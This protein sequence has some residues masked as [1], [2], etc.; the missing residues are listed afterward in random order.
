M[1]IRF[2]KTDLGLDWGLN[3][4]V[5]MPDETTELETNEMARMLK[6]AGYESI[7]SIESDP[8]EFNDEPGVLY[9]HYGRI[10]AKQ[11]TELTEKERCFYLIS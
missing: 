5:S 10:E 8:V 9:D 2:D 6:L 1:R 7:E 3:C 4:Y 11:Y